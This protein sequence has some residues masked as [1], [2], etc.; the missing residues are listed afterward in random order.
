MTTKR[1]RGRWHPSPAQISLAIDAAAAKLPLDRAAELIGIKPRSLWLFGR[2]AGLPLF[3][4]WRDRPR[5][6]AISSG[7]VGSRTAEAPEAVP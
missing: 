3:G 2:R 4:I 7:P 5:Y 6:K 1:V